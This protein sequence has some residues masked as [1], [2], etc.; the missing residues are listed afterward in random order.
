MHT[1]GIYFNFVYNIT[2]VITTFTELQYLVAHVSCPD[3][4]NKR[5]TNVRSL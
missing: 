4:Y 1:R 2:I 5:V 3:V